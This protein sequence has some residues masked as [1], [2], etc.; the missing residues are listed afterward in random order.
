MGLTPFLLPRQ[1]FHAS[2]PSPNGFRSPTGQGKA[3]QRV[4]LLSCS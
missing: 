2:F 4:E 1:Y 3:R